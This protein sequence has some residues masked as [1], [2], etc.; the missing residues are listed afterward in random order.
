MTC[1]SR[2][3]D[4]CKS[5]WR[6][7]AWEDKSVLEIARWVQLWLEVC[8]IRAA[9]FRSV[10]QAAIPQGM[11]LQ[12]TPNS[13][14]TTSTVWMGAFIMC[15]CLPTRHLYFFSFHVNMRGR[16][17][18]SHNFRDT[19]VLSPWLQLFLG[20]FLSCV[21]SGWPSQSYP[22]KCAWSTESQT[23]GTH[24]HCTSVYS[25]TLTL[26]FKHCWG[27]M[28]AV[29]EISVKDPIWLA[30]VHCLQ[31][32]YLRAWFWKQLPTL[33]QAQNLSDLHPKIERHTYLTDAS[34]QSQAHLGSPCI[35]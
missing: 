34:F 9:G 35:S 5:W 24:A 28:V 8:R 31:R 17:Y 2:D 18:F 25:H 10:R 32:K 22:Q 15:I 6:K 1:L 3:K 21:S 13:Y 26:A 29:A 12:K 14:L 27:V 16:L 33:P 30:R 11:W 7:S 23:E 20:T 4:T 19:R